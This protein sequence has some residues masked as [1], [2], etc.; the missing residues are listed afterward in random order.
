MLPVVYCNQKGKL[1]N[2]VTLGQ[3]DDTENNNQ[4][5]SVTDHFCEVIYCTVM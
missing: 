4:I 2:V 3:I 1:V 5:I